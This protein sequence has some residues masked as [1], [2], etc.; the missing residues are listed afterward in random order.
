MRQSKVPYTLVPNIKS[1]RTDGLSFQ[2]ECFADAGDF[3]VWRSTDLHEWV[4]VGN[5]SIQTPNYPGV[6]FREDMAAD[7]STASYQL[8]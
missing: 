1:P 5:V 7:R 6:V 4:E 2:F 3:S 8:R